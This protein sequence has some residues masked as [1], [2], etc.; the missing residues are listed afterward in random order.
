MVTNNNLE[1]TGFVLICTLKHHSQQFI[2]ENIL[3]IK[4]FFENAICIS[5]SI[6]LHSFHSTELLL[7][8]IFLE[9]FYR[10]IFFHNIVSIFC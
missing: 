7:H 4:V 1:G 2:Y 6:L 3:K 8:I 9:N 5:N 10:T